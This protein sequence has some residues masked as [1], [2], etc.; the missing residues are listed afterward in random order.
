[1]L[2]LIFVGLA[3]VLG[4]LYVW[5]TQKFNYWEEQGIKTR[6][7]VYPFIGSMWKVWKRMYHIE[8]AKDIR[9]HGRRIGLYEGTRPY[10]LCADLDILRDVCIKNFDYF[11]DRMDPVITSHYWRK[12][13]SILIGEEWKEVR[14]HLSPAFS[15]GKIKKMSALMGECAHTL[16]GNFLESVQHKTGVVDLK[17]QYGAFTMDVV[18]TCAFGTKIDSLGSP[19]DPFVE[20]A[21]KAFSSRKNQSPLVALLFISRWIPKLL[22]GIFFTK[23]LR[24]FLEVAKSIA[25]KRKA[26]NNRERGDMIDLMLDVQ[27]EE[28]KECETDPSKT[29]V[30]TE[31]VIIA[32]QTVLFFLAGYDTTAT[33]LTMVTYNLALHPEAQEKAVAEIRE[34][35]AQ[36]VSPFFIFWLEV[37]VL[38]G[39]ITHEMV[40]DCPYLDQ[41]IQESLRLYPPAL[42]LERTCT[43]ACEIHGVKFEKGVR[44]GFPIYAIHH[45]PEFFEEPEK[46]HPERF[47]QSEK[48][49]QHPMTYLPFGQGPRSCIG[50]RFAQMEI[51]LALCHVLSQIKFSRCSQTPVPVEARSSPNLL[52]Q[53]LNVM[54]EIEARK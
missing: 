2:A 47:A 42:R 51:K 5:N 26:E 28:Q 44:I 37:H 23:E 10:L 52:F 39:G 24:F 36:H 18:A 14:R 41:V 17:Q 20:N 21:R 29:P 43:K 48:G 45:D 25:E 16:V 22:S 50:M 9:I 31:E 15:S 11:V 19:D 38:L 13:L 3:V 54:V 34:K 4:F 8:D 35:I 1:M 30:I 27:E 6:P 12:M 46:F 49:L 32:Q 40:I 53:P 7:P 33:T